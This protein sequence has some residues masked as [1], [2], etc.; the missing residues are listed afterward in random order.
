MKI[1]ENEK[2]DGIR[3]W[4]NDIKAEQKGGKYVVKNKWTLDPKV[5]VQTSEVAAGG[6][7]SS[8][9]NHGGIN[10]AATNVEMSNMGINEVVN[11]VQGN[12]EGVMAL[13]PTVN[14]VNMAKS[15]NNSNS[16]VAPMLAP[17]EVMML[18]N[19]DD[20]SQVE[21]EGLNVDGGDLE[22]RKRS[23]E[24]K[25]I[26]EGDTFYCDSQGGF[27]FGDPKASIGSTTVFIN[28]N[29]VYEDDNVS[30]AP[31]YQACRES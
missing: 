10:E 31:D 30:A 4:S 27:C 18:T 20:S 29:P 17:T 7:Q 24:D 25:R 13:S 22:K 16:G 12:K 1:F 15:G 6:G 8:A 21:N 11:S 19:S 23:N 28:N 5:E 9:S 14:V 2:D 26:K 3:G